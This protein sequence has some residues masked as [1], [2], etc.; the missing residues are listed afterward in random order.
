[1][2]LLL[3]G[4]SSSSLVIHLITI[5][6]FRLKHTHSP[7]ILRNFFALGNTILL[8]EIYFRTLRLEFSLFYCLILGRTK[9]GNDTV[10]FQLLMGVYPVCRNMNYLAETWV[11]IVHLYL[12][13]SAAIFI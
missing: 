9:G 13:Y 6:W 11:F 12:L 7:S 10:I 8:T 4:S 2:N 5:I 1:M 3:C